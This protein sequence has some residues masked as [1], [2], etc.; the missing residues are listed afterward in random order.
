MSG[1]VRTNTSTHP[2]RCTSA[3][4]SAVRAALDTIHDPCSVRTGKPLGLVA[5]GLIESVAID[6][7]SIG[8]RIVVTGPGCFFY[9]Q[10]AESI[11]RAL[12][13]IAGSREIDVAIDDSILWTRERM[14]EP[15]RTIAIHPV[16][17]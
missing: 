9:F 2:G 5:M 1:T 10:F 15:V 3:L 17:A 4:E 7:A 14:R 11:E 6:D 13:D 8:I 16:G 12:A